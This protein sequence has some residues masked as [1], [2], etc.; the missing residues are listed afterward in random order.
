MRVK[1]GMLFAI[2]VIIIL[3]NSSFAQKLN[4]KLNVY[5]RELSFKYKKP[6]GFV[7]LD[8]GTF[9]K[10]N[11]CDWITKNKRKWHLLLPAPFEYTIIS[12]RRD[13]VIAFMIMPRFNAHDY[14]RVI[15]LDADTMNHSIIHYSRDYLKKETNATEASL[16]VP[17]CPYLYKKEYPHIKVVIMYKK[18]EGVIQLFYYYTDKTED[19]IDRCIKRTAD[20][21]RFNT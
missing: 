3:N 1:R 20:M 19:K 18:E 12:K 9:V 11:T 15:Q 2:L 5:A 10:T 4:R 14:Y 16:Y 21:I 13:I 6:L 7:E 17:N 8:S